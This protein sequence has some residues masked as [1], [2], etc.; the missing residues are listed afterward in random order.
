MV[1]VGFTLTRDE[2]IRL[3]RGRQARNWT[4]WAF[5]ALGLVL[6]AFGVWFRAVEIVTVGV[7]YTVWLA[8]YAWVWVPARIWRR[9]VQLHS[10]QTIT[11]SDAGVAT[12]MIDSWV[13]TDWGYWCKV[14]AVRDGYVISARTNGWMIIPTRAFGSRDD[15]DAFRQIIGRHIAPSVAVGVPA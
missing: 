13:K 1:T 8:G 5:V 2:V 12:Q 4:N 11:F 7:V 3:Y 6:A 10:E 14:E 9:E 15:E